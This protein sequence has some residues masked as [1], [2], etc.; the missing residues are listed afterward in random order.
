VSSAPVSPHQPVPQPSA[1]ALLSKAQSTTILETVAEPTMSTHAAALLSKAQSTTALETVAEPAMGT[2]AAAQTTSVQGQAVP[3]AFSDPWAPL[4][5][6]TGV[7]AGVL[8]LVT[9]PFLTNSP[10]AP[11]EPPALWALLAWVRRE[12]WRSF[13]DEKSTAQ[14]V[15][16]VFNLAE[17]DKALGPFPSDIFTVHDTDQNTGLRV[18]LPLPDPAVRPS[19]YAD[20][21]AINTL[22][23]FNITP[24]IS[25]PF[26]GEI[27]LSTVNSQTVFLQKLGSTLPNNE[28]PG[29]KRVGINHVVWDAATST[30]HVTANDTL[31]QHTRYVLVVTT[32]VKDKNGNP[33]GSEAF[34]RFRHDLNFGQPVTH[35]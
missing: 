9:S 35:A 13:Y 31:D 28:G 25:I 2:H 17:R 26:N 16:V 11:A 34:E 8:G 21:S 23:G 15:Q 22:D 10:V 4:N 20:I 3:A 7:V 30:L 24:R 6:V 33:V 12:S 29:A 27:D 32:G 18:D 1:A 5:I 19:D 14:P